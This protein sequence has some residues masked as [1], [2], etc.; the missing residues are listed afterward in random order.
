MYIIY[1][2]VYIYIIHTYIYIYI[3]S[4]FFLLVVIY[5][6]VIY[7]GMIYPAVIYP[8][9]L[10]VSRGVQPDQQLSTRAEATEGN[11]VIKWRSPTL[12]GMSREP[13]SYAVLMDQV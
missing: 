4:L 3:Y 8:T 7:P 11:R 10:L 12:V 6:A 5:I 1:I 2:Y 13:T 9:Y